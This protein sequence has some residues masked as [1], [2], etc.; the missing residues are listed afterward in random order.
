MECYCDYYQISDGRKI[1]FARI[2]LVGL[3]RIYWILIEI[4]RERQCKNPIKS[5]EEMKDKLKE[6]YLYEFYRNHL[7]DEL[8]DLH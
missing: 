7:Q 6:K 1:R 4:A 8:H 2:K 3:D 5:W